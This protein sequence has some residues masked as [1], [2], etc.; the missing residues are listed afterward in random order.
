[1]FMIIIIMIII[2]MIME[3]IISI[4]WVA[5]PWVREMGGAP[6]NPAPMEPLF[7]A[8]CQTIML[9]LHR[10]ALD[11]QS[12]YRGLNHIVELTLYVCV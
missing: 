12:F 7:G 10:W 3:I 1:M 6:G 2:I 4:V 11:K 8:E 5:R 9:P